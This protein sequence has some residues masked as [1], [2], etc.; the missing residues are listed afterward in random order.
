VVVVGDVMLDVV[1]RPAGPLVAGGDRDAAITMR[2]GGSAANVAAAA[3]AAGAEAHL[4]AA[5][6]DAGGPLL[7]PWP[8]PVWSP[9]CGRAG[10]RPAASWR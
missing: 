8:G 6:G 9:I 10:G 4:V 1:A 7:P 2:F 3:A 5:V